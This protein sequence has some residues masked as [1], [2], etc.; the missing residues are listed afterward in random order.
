ME[1]RK[2]TLSDRSFVLA[3]IGT[4]DDLTEQIEAA[5][6]A[7]GGFVDIH[8]VGGGTVA[9]LITERTT[10]FV[11]RFEVQP[12]ELNSGA[13]SAGGYLDLDFG[14]DFDYPSRPPT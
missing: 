2:L 13:Q 6:R 9:A 8:L 5:I 14:V 1:T 3:S 11:E 7:G 12:E 10:A 4:A